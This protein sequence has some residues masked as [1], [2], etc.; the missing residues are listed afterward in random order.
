[1]ISYHILKYRYPEWNNLSEDQFNEFAENIHS[2]K[3]NL[4]K[5]L[6]HPFGD[7]FYQICEKYDTPFLLL[8]D[9]LSKNPTEAKEKLS[10]PEL[11]EVLI[12]AH[13]NQ[14][15]KTLKKRLGRAAFYAT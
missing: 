3:E 4:E 14:R 5:D 12:T 8:G 6:D 7:K 1:M 15:V 2:I 9:V 13:Y 11:L 10:D